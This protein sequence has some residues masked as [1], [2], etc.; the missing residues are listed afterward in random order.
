MRTIKIESQNPTNED[1]KQALYQSIIM[2]FSSLVAL[3][4]ASYWFFPSLALL[5]L[6]YMF[7]SQ[8]IEGSYERIVEYIAIAIFL[9]L[10]AF[11]Y[12]KGKQTIF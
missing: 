7:K 5:I 12:T 11:Y 6:L 9:I 8:W 3:I 1:Y 4:T 2:A 10:P